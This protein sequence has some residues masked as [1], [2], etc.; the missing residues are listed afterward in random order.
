MKTTTELNSKI[1]YRFLKVIYVLI[2][3]PIFIV[4]FF[5]GYWDTMPQFDSEN[6]YLKCDNGGKVNPK[7][8]YSPYLTPSED[9][10]YRKYCA[11]ESEV[12]ET[13]SQEEFTA[14]W[15]NL[16]DKSIPKNY[17]VISIYTKRD[18][19]KTIGISA[20]WTV[21]AILIFELLKR[22][23]YYIVLGSFIPPK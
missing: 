19:L 4:A 12:G 3:I 2:F 15:K 13:L 18:W 9:E 11:I 7:N 6:S 22:I 23:F 16:K 17:E 1:W 8:W 21:V 5:S 10:T 14:Q 20:L